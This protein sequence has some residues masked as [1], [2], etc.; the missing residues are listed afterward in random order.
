MSISVGFYRTK[1][2]RTKADAA[3]KVSN[4]LLK[5]MR[6]AFGKE[7]RVT[8][9]KD[10]PYL[11]KKQI[12][13]VAKV[14]LGILA[15]LLFPITLIG[16]ALAALSK[17][18]RVTYDDYRTSKKPES[19][20]LKPPKEDSKDLP[21]KL[22]PRKDALQENPSKEIEKNDVKEVPAAKKEANEGNVE[23]EIIDAKEL[24]YKRT[25]KAVEAIYKK[26]FFNDSFVK[27][28]RPPHEFE[29]S[30][31]Y[32]EGKANRVAET[33][34]LA[35]RK[36]EIQGFIILDRFFTDPQVAEFAGRDINEGSV[37]LLGVNPEMKRSG[38]GNAL[39]LE[40]MRK[41]KEAGKHSLRLAFHSPA[42]MNDVAK[43]TDPLCQFFESFKKKYNI[44][45]NT[46]IFSEWGGNGIDNVKITYDLNTDFSKYPRYTSQKA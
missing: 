29:V 39:M 25:K 13:T 2:S 34:L 19:S 7:V 1:M 30:P 4:V 14:F 40:M 31:G 12:N 41:V 23:I 20:D 27:D 16:M 9:A 44:K 43:E 18:H 28:R 37:A 21:S 46:Q 11:D 6:L 22:N 3:E 15:I 5:P 45:S 26:A 42:K 8:L 38:I 36:N 35:K 10:N 32:F 33:I 24:G 17:S